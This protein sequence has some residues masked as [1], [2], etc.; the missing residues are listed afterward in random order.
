MAKEEEKPKVKL[1]DSE[2]QGV[3]IFIEQRNGKITPVSLEL[4]G[5]G[6]K[7]AD[8][9][10]VEL[11][12][13]LLGYKVGHLVDTLYQYGADTVYLIDDPVL[14]QYRSEAYQVGVVDVVK[15]YKPEILLFGATVIGRDLASTVA[16][17][18]GTGLTADTTRLDID[19]KNR[20]L[21]A[22]RPAMGGN[23]MATILCKEKRPQMASV[24]PK[25]FKAI[26]P[27]EGRKGKLIEETINL[28]EED[29]K[30]KVI[31]VIQEVS[32]KI[33]LGDAD[34][35]VAGGKGLQDEKGFQLIRDLAKELG[36][37][38]GA[39]RD[40]VEAGWAEHSEQVGQTG[41]TVAPKLYFA[42]G[43]SGAVQHT[44][45]MEN[46]EIVVAINRDP[47]AQIFEKCTY[48]IVGDAFEI[49]PKF[50]EEFKKLAK[51]S[52]EVNNG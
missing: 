15:K 3:W 6:R 31:E 35:I 42:I 40:A 12:G 45:G 11:S 13:V 19:M 41:T 30:T 2:Y 38:V 43:I 29:L 21:E 34:I 44:V 1:P 39:S 17:E 4:L 47:N 36:A 48:G 20:L 22:S 37:A 50:I 5:E 32:D 7:L 24:R 16:T 23:I 46:S 26:K 25:V 51:K 49:V 9:L 27:V 10:G 52:G 14:E 18:L 33:R 8:K 28:N